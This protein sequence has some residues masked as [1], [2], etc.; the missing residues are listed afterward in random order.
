[1]RGRIPA[2]TEGKASHV[3]QATFFRNTGCLVRT[4]RRLQLDR[5]RQILRIKVL[6]NLELYRINVNKSIVDHEIRLSV[7][8]L[9]REVPGPIHKIGN[10]EQ[11]LAT[12][13]RQTVEFE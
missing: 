1:F 2:L 10:E 9:F 6:G 13:G 7:G 8:D 5:A 11:T 12:C 4:K 3:Q